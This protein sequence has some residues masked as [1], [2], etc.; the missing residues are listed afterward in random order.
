MCV[1]GDT[2]LVADGIYTGW[3]NKNLTFDGLAITVRSENGP[4]DCII[5]C[6]GYGRAFRRGVQASTSG[7]LRI[8]TSRHSGGLVRPFVRRTSRPQC[9]HRGWRPSIASISAMRQSSCSSTR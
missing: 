4:D 3:L 7:S 6:N 2:V 5:D 1:D 9:P 8:F